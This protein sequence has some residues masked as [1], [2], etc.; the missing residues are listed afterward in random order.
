MVKS[1]YKQTEIGV[2][3]EDWEAK[4]ICELA[5]IRM[6]K[7]IF[8]EQTSDY[9]DIPFYKIGTF[10]GK[11]DAYISR[12]LYNEYTS[13]YSYPEKGDILI[14]AAG[15]LGR[16]VVFDGSESYFQDSNIVWLDIDKKQLC[17]EYLK[18]YYGVIRWAASEGSTISRL[19]NGIIESTYIAVPPLAEQHRIAEALSDM[20]ELIAS[21]E[22]LIAK[23]KA[24]KQGAMQELLTGKCRLPGFSGEWEDNKIG[25]MGF[26]YNGLS[27]KKKDDFGHGKARYITFLNVLSNVII[28]LQELEYVEVEQEELQ[29][30][31]NKGDLFFNTSSETP[32]EVGMCAALMTDV[33]NIY[34]NSFCFGFRLFNDNHDP[35]FLSYLFNSSVG[36]KIMRILAQGATRYNLSKGSLS[37]VKVKLPA[38]AEQTALATALFEMDCEIDALEKRHKKARQ[39]KLGMMQQLLTG[40]KRLV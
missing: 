22:K 36:R 10:G 13:K 2:I 31:V 15:T 32:E 17:N 20:D 19:Y 14:S 40:K 24:V 11:P 16:T 33:A 18:Q 1:G 23:K 3:P 9:G 7:R 8:A 27:G 12:A 6:C 37:D 5:N 34:L 30:Q 29:N 38:K 21:L 4:P 25:K 35:L 28:D 39:I 26:F